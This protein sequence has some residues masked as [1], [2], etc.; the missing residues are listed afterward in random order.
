MEVYV[1]DLSGVCRT[2]S[3]RVMESE[4]GKWVISFLWLCGYCSWGMM[5]DDMDICR[6]FRRVEVYSNQFRVSWHFLYVLG[7]PWLW[8][9]GIH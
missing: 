7:L 2:N 1:T 8:S 9:R 6:R 4:V 5:I 3:R